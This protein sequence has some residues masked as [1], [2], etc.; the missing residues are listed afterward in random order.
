M[1]TF[2]LDEFDI[3]A[4][5]FVTSCTSSE[6]KE[7]LG[8]LIK[9]DYIKPDSILDYDTSFSIPEQEFEDALNKLHGKYTTL[10]KEEEEIIKVIAKRF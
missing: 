8:Y 5:E 7:L 1:P 2:P 10:S 9:E 3:D 4:E 6:I